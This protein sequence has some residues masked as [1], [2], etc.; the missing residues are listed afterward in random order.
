MHNSP[1]GEAEAQGKAAQGSGGWRP[2]AATSNTLQQGW[3]GP[4]GARIRLARA[5]EGQAAVD[6]LWLSG[7]EPEPAVLQGL[8]LGVIGVA[9]KGTLDHG[10]DAILREVALVLQSPEAIGQV[11]ASLGMRMVAVDAQGTVVGAL[12]A[13][14]PT[15]FLL[16]LRERG[17]ASKTCSSGIAL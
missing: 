12:L 15:A 8:E 11:S 16:G 2:R 7:E 17:L 1:H 4:G 9:L 14:P 3:A 5:E 10:H 6:L 13:H